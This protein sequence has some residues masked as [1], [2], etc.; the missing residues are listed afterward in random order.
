MQTAN[1]SLAPTNTL[2]VEIGGTAPGNGF[3]QIKDSGTLTLGGTLQVV[4]TGGFAPA[5]GNTFDILDWGTMSGRFSA[6]QLPSLAAP[7]GWDTTRLY[8][9]G[10]L[11][12][13]NFVPGDFNRDGHADA[14]DIAAMLNALTDLNTFKAR[15][16]L[17][18]AD[19]LSIGDIDGSGAVTNADINALIGL[20]RTG[21]GSVTA[22]PEP[23]SVEL[24]S[25][26]LLA[27][28]LFASPSEVWSIVIAR[29][30]GR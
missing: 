14:S 30:A 20:L 23:A 29:R 27:G 21:G 9:K 8:T 13:T 3:D 28:M 5:N 15:N 1:L 24:L 16:G 2:I 12:V 7:L 17:S 4:L 6:L 11:A 25:L 18:D 26:G 19:L 10:T 22:L